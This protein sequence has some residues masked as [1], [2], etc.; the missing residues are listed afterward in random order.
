VCPTGDNEN[1]RIKQ[2]RMAK[3]KSSSQWLRR[4]VT[5]GYVHK[6]KEQGYRSRAAFKLLD[7]D[8]RDRLLRPGSRIVD[9]G[10]A[11]GGW[12]QV[13]ARSSGPGGRVVAI[14]LL[15]IEPISGVVI[16]QGDFLSAAAREQVAAA[17]GGKA[18]LVLSDLSPNLSGIAAA[19]QAR[20][21]ELVEQA[22][23]FA[24]ATLA[25]KGAFVCKMFHGAAFDAIVADLKRRFFSVAVRKPAASRGES[26]ETYVVAREPRQA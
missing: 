11:P 18:D 1:R 5:D 24:S 15:R 13:A 26:K 10:G 8:A 23:I 22:A 4:H 25:P 17:L 2:T 20:M 12:S 19:D 16:I 9:L 3:S 6:A 14:D 21:T 7:I